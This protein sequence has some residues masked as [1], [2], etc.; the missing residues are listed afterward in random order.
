[1]NVGVVLVYLEEFYVFSDH[2][3][4]VIALLPILYAYLSQQSDQNLGLSPLL[5]FLA[6]HL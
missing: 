1:M 3:V 2:F 6:L 4:E 5:S